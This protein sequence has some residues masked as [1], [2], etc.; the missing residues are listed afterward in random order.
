MRIRRDFIGMFD[1]IKG[2]LMLLIVLVHH[3][4]FAVAVENGAVARGLQWFFQYSVVM[5]GLFFICAGYSVVPVKNLKEYVKKQGKMLLI[6]YFGVMAASAVLASALAFAKGE[7]RIQEISTRVLAFLYGS[8]RPFELFGLV[9]VA[10]VVAMWFL[11]TLFLGG[12]LQQLFLRIKNRKAAQGCIWALVAA[13]AALPSTEQVH[14][15][16][17]LVQGC[18]AL[19]FLE[20]GRLLKTHKVLYRPLNL[21]FIGGTA[22]LWVCLHCFSQANVAANIW[23]L[24]MLDYIG[25]AAFA[26]VVL[27]LYL[28]SGM[29]ASYWIEPFAYIGRHSLYFLCIHGTELLVFPWIAELRPELLK[30]PL[31]VEVTVAGMFILRVALS[32]AG[33]MIMVK[34]GNWRRRQNIKTISKG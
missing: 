14:I 16:W 8:V 33:C 5:I 17:F 1:G 22:V 29:A 28:A 12:L 4:S 23:K 24:W 13:A 21:W 19:G 6:P 25:G 2:I 20:I 10:A 26:V 18:T 27:Q 34:I 32:V 30:L 11:P 15:P 9:W 7:F 3:V 31:P